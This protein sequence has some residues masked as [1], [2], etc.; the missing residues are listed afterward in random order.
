MSQHVQIRSILIC[1]SKAPGAGKKQG[2]AVHSL[3]GL[4]NPCSGSPYMASFG[5]PLFSF[6]GRTHP[7]D[8]SGLHRKG[9]ASQ[10]PKDLTGW[11]AEG[12]RNSVAISDARMHQ[13]RMIRR[14]RTFLAG[15]A[16]LFMLVASALA[17]GAG[18]RMLSADS[19]ALAA[20]VQAG[21]TPADICDDT[22]GDH[23]SGLTGCLACHIVGCADV[24]APDPVPRAAG[25]VVAAVVTAPQESRALR[26]VFDF[27]H[28]M[29]APPL[30]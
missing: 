24:P 29:R 26:P 15:L 6:H 25:L 13:D 27:A 3:Q 23:G 20:F 4:V 11:A 12:F 5:Q 7:A 1:S 19:L 9:G 28:A 18:H 2:F 10:I 22:G 14:L 16:L 21:G 17:S 8:R 30:A